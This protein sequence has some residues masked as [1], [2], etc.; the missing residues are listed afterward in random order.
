MPASTNLAELDSIT[1]FDF[2]PRTRVVYGP[3]T[4]DRVG[5]LSKEIGGTRALV[6]TDDG[7]EQAGHVDRV[8]G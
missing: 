5:E 3:G 6:V 7:I 4:V 1:P 8:V 2:D